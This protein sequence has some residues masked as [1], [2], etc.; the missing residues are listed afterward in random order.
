MKRYDICWADLE[1]VRGAEM[2]KTRPVV[3][4]SLDTLNER[5][6]TVTICPLAT[7]LHPQWR[8]RVQ[9]R[10]AGKLVEIAVD[11]IRTLSKTRL[12][13]KTGALSAADAA[14]LRRL[15]TEMYGE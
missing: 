7:Q 14:A 5:L 8:S 10:C 9:V 13:G 6:Q 11:Q 1:P 3:V 4:V 15:I 12:G 2:A